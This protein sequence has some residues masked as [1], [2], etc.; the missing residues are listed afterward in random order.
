MLSERFVSNIES[1]NPVL[2]PLTESRTRGS[3]V[4]LV[5][6]GKEWD[7]GVEVDVAVD[8]AE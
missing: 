7:L 6:H 1:R 3:V 5:G 2:K 4:S 8:A